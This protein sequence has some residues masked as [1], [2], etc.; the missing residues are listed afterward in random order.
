MCGINGFSALGGFASGENSRRL[1]ERMNKKIQHRG[2]DGEGIYLDNDIS[3]GHRRLSI[4][5]LSENGKQPMFNEDKSLCLIFNG[6]IY[7]FQELKKDLI[8][9]GHKFISETDSEVIL[10]LFEE[11]KEDCVKLLNG[12][13][14]FAIWDI[15]NKELFLAR[16]RIGVK[17]LYYYFKDNKFI[18]SSE[19]KA[20]LE[21]DIQR[22]IDL[23]ALNYYF[24]LVY[25]PAPLT[26]F[27][28]IHKLP[29]A[30]W[31]RFKVAS[32]RGGSNFHN[33]EIRKYWDIED[34]EE[35]KSKAEIIE[36]IQDLM[37]ES[38]K[39]QLISDRPVGIFLS[40]GID[41]TSVLGVSREFKKDRI[42]T[43][44]VGF[45]IEDPNNKFNADFN[46]ARETAKFYNT[47]HRELFVGTKDILSNLEKVIYH[48]DEP[49]AEPTQTATFLLSEMAKKEVAVVLGGDGG[50]ELFGG[51]KRYYYS[52]ILNRYLPITPNFLMTEVYA[53]F[54]FQK[55]TEIEKIL[56]KDINNALI[57]KKFFRK[58]TKNYHTGI[59]KSFM[60][61]D[62]NTWLVD[63]SLM[64]TDKMT[65]AH[66][67]EQRVPILDH[68]LV[69]LSSKI[70]SKYKIL[71]KD[72]GKAIFIEA[73]KQYLPEHILKSDKKKVWLTP[74]SEW[75][76]RG[77]NG[78]A[79]EAL[80]ADYCLESKKYFD[81]NGIQRMF[82]DHI[83][84]RKY[85][86]NLIWALI[87]FQI[88]CK[89][90]LII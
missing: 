84:K 77:L 20:I 53:K 42:K 25:V 70:P 13:F 27:K 73:M 68:Y 57:T 11:H 28:N 4:I 29:Q 33:P 26:M 14:A 46:L 80:S 10:H 52:H 21:H 6:E 39:G 60:L 5:D 16:D 85:N 65:M 71:N 75:L 41:S 86:L 88:W 58:K 1:I 51:Y 67:L 81:F 31:L 89:K 59:A 15:K 78:F 83:E 90:Y 40:G 74:M 45:D 3:L 24:R 49:I 79:K 30:H 32:A 69:E 54:M 2:P 12:I 22:E 37:R 17:P 61:T 48:L 36:K 7:N 34:F 62:L 82:D 38:V 63:E 56:S 19:I 76:R 35:I 64:R 23:D 18:F 43:F 50:D 47:E 87:T 44:S 55:E 8:N 72:Q 66:G 9:K